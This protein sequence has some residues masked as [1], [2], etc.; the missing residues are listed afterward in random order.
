MHIVYFM[1]FFA[2]VGEIRSSACKHSL[3]NYPWA[4]LRFS[5]RWLIFSSYVC[6]FSSCVRAFLFAVLFYFQTIFICQQ[7]R[8]MFFERIVRNVL[9]GNIISRLL[10]DPTWNA[11]KFCLE[12][13]LISTN[14]IHIRSAL[15]ACEKSS[16]R[17]CAGINFE[18]G[19]KWNECEF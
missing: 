10:C 13:T 17:S 12:Q 14:Y 15:C 9:T 11:I 3:I 19:E 8:P 4:S 16:S 1:S 5:S 7:R 18:R 6:I 2:R